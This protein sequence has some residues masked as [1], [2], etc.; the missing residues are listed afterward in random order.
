MSV[1]HTLLR[2][3]RSGEPCTYISAL[4][5]SFQ[6]SSFRRA[7]SLMRYMFSTS[8]LSLMPCS[9][10]FIA[11]RPSRETRFKFGVYQI[12]DSCGVHPSFTPPRLKLT[13]GQL[14]SSGHRL[15]PVQT[16]P[17]QALSCHRRPNWGLS[18][19]CSPFTACRGQST[20]D[21]ATKSRLRPL[22]HQTPFPVHPRHCKTRLPDW[23]PSVAP[24]CVR[25]FS[26]SRSFTLS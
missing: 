13:L 7:M 9:V 11:L 16:P 10:V 12:R 1:V 4:R 5:P 17:P 6:T 24:P 18:P 8:P 2:G 25:S 21:S 23:R 19:N 14:L 15:S 3:L 22:R 20:P 26:A